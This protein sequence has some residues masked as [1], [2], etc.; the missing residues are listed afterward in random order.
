MNISDSKGFKYGIAKSSS[1]P[2]GE[3]T[4]KYCSRLDGDGIHYRYCSCVSHWS[5]A[6]RLEVKASLR[7]VPKTEGQLTMLLSWMVLFAAPI[8]AVV[9]PPTSEAAFDFVE[10]RDDQAPF[11][12]G[13]DTKDGVVWEPKLEATQASAQGVSPWKGTVGWKGV[14]FGANGAW[15]EFCK[16]QDCTP[17][18]LKEGNIFADGRRISTFKQCANACQDP[19]IQA[20]YVDNTKCR[21][22]QWLKEGYKG[23]PSCYFYHFAD[24][25]KDMEFT[26]METLR[27][28]D[29]WGSSGIAFVDQACDTPELKKL[30]EKNE[31]ATCCRFS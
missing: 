25:P 17:K 9:M 24:F 30:S 2:I 1:V 12:G 13:D 21:A 20:Q 28:N 18:Q 23:L 15:E 3:T 31:N 19:N 27:D 14:Q 16:I 11:C 7:L 8:A 26:N 6:I 5:E 4:S 29:D 10:K 22:V